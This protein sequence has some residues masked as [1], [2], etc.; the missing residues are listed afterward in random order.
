MQGRCVA[1]LRIDKGTWVRPV[2]TDSDYGQLYSK[3]YRLIDGSHAEVLDVLR[4]D[5]VDRRPTLAQPENWALGDERWVLL[6][7][8]APPR[9]YG[10]L[11]S[12]LEEGPSLFGSFDKRVR[13]EEAANSDASLALVAPSRL[14]WY[15]GN[16]FHGRPQPRVIFELSGAAY[17]LPI[18]DPAWTTRIVKA[19]HGKGATAETQDAL[20]VSPTNAVLLTISMG[21]A[22]KGYCYKLVAGIVVIPDARAWR[23]LPQSASPTPRK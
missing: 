10:I 16:D 21:E 4:I 23:Q 7:R 9:L 22:Y 3:H 20:G 13:S 12:A 11:Y 2:A 18:T 19:L 17:D 8:P 1:G 5:L 15:V 14:Q 6:S